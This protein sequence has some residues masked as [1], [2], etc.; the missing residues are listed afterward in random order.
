[1]EGTSSKVTIDGFQSM[2]CEAKEI[3]ELEANYG[4]FTQDFGVRR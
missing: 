4:H 2:A 3:P 1:M